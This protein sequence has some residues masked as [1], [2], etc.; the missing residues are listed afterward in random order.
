MTS[1]ERNEMGTTRGQA[2]RTEHSTQ[3]C[4]VDFATFGTEG[5]SACSPGAM[6][7]GMARNGV[8][9]PTATVSCPM[10]KMCEG[11]MKG[12]ARGLGLLLLIPA[13]VLLTLGATILFV[14]KILT[15]LVAGGLVLVGGLILVAAC[16]VRRL[17]PPAA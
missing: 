9:G 11:M 14:P 10:A 13:A 15:W 3:C 8:E 4:G 16:R 17:S 6:M 2:T 7:A 1:N 12:G 5:S